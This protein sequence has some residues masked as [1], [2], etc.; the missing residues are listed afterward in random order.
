MP[1]RSYAVVGERGIVGGRGTHV[2]RQDGGA[3]AEQADGRH[4]VE[5]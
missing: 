3:V 4:D 1:S 2:D 5:R